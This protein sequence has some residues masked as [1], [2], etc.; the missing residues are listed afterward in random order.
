[1][2]KQFDESHRERYRGYVLFLHG[3]PEE[4]Y[5][6]RHF[7]AKRPNPAVGLVGATEPPLHQNASCGTVACAAG[8]M[9]VYD[10]ANWH[11]VSGG[12]PRLRT[13]SPDYRYGHG[14]A[15]Y[16]D[17]AV[18][19]DITISEAVSI[20]GATTYPAYGD[21]VPKSAVIRRL[22]DTAARYGL[23]IKLPEAA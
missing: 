3:V 4:G 16:G 11:V 14:Y 22:I 13:V 17:V 5:D 1:M 7:Y 2:L 20:C 8:W 21:K 9:V 10:P 19:L 23:E 12:Y 15:V 18:Y 6:Q